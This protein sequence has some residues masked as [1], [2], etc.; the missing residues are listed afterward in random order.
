MKE[1]FKSKFPDLYLYINELGATK[2][3]IIFNIYFKT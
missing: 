2:L 1:L 3:F